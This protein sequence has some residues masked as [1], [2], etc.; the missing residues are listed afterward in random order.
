MASQPTNHFKTHATLLGMLNIFSIT[1]ENKNEMKAKSLCQQA[2]LKLSR[3][4]L[5][6]IKLR[7]DALR[8]ALHGSSPITFER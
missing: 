3:T 2:L 8:C 5:H 4:E 6:L 7:C 1:K